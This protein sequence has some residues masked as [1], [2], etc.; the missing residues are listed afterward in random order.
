MWFHTLRA[1]WDTGGYFLHEW[2]GGNERDTG[3][4]ERGIVFEARRFNQMVDPPVV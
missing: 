2:G 3:Y 1:G 4:G